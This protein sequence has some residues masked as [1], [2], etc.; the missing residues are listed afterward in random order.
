MF[1][2]SPVCRG[3]LWLAAAV[4][5]FLINIMSADSTLALLSVAFLVWWYTHLADIRFTLEGKYLIKETG[6]TFKRKNIILLKNISY[7]QVFTLHPALPA[8]VRVHT[9][10]RSLLI[11]GL[12]GRQVT[13][14]ERQIMQLK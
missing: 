7:I 12:N 4:L 2:V 3:L 10:S 11:I 8:L 5:I 1:T 14:L 9:Y 6:K 13:A